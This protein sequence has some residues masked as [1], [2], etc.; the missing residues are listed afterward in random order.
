MIKLLLQSQ[1][2]LGGKIYPLVLQLTSQNLTK[3]SNSK[4][5]KTRLIL[6]SL[7]F[8]CAFGVQLPFIY[9]ST[10]LGILQASPEVVSFLCV[11][12]C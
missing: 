11:I 9:Q 8:K 7:T 6:H 2:F 3:M 5:S 4:N 1:R 10:Q 12:T